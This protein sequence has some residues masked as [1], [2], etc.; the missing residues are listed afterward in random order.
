[1][2]TKKIAKRRIISAPPKAFLISNTTIGFGNGK[3][4]IHLSGVGKEGRRRTVGLSGLSCYPLK[5]QKPTNKVSEDGEKL[6][7][8]FLWQPLQCSPMHLIIPSLKDNI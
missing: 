6:T 4:Y 8:F 7:N 5:T 2:K 3:L 1:L